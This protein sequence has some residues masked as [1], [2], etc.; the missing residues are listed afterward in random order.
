[1]SAVDALLVLAAQDR[2]DAALLGRESAILVDRELV[3][4]NRVAESAR[5]AAATGAYRTVLTVLAA[6]LPPLLAY[7]RAP[8]GLS[9]LLSVAAECAERC[10]AVAAEPIPGLTALA[11]RGGSS[12]LVRHAARLQAA[13]EKR[14]ETTAFDI[15]P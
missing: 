7:E 13:W 11:A 5:T 1:L 10:G 8:R 4:P 6:A 15:L 12:Q 2:L 9:D 14:S 3:K